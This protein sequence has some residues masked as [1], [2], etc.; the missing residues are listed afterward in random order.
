MTGNT[1]TGSYVL[2]RDAALRA[3][4]R[5]DYIA[6]LARQSRIKGTQVGRKWYVDATDLN[7]FL[8]AQSSGTKPRQRDVHTVARTPGR[9][10]S[11][12]EDQKIVDAVAPHAHHVAAT[13]VRHA[14]FFSAPGVNAHAVSYVIHPGMDFFHKLVALV[15]AIVIVFSVYGV[16]DREFGNA[17]I[18]AIAYSTTAGAAL[19]AAFFGA[20]P[21]CHSGAQ[22]MA[23]TAYI[24]M[25]N[26]LVSLDNLLAI[27]STD[28][29]AVAMNHDCV[30]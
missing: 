23:A 24:S 7:A 28:T 14:N 16:F 19:A 13:G 25:H 9:S 6:R 22:R 12:I 26:I 10:T 3:N 5:P 29:E 27:R 17:A 1:D 20:S 2:A 8:A 11:T 18:N 21:D 4:V 30:R 15:T